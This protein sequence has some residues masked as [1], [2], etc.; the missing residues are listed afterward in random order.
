MLICV[1]ALVAG[2]IKEQGIARR[3]MAQSNAIDQTN[4]VAETVLD[5]S[6]EMS[7]LDDDRFKGGLY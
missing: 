5:W 2:I 6:S 1:N 7:D 4:E 3:L